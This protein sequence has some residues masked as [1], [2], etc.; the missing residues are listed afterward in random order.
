[1]QSPQ[2]PSPDVPNIEPVVS[3]TVDEIMDMW[4]A[5]VDSV[6]HIK[7]LIDVMQFN[8]RFTSEKDG[9]KCAGNFACSNMP[10]FKTILSAARKRRKRLMW[11]KRVRDRIFDCK[12]ALYKIKQVLLYTLS[13]PEAPELFSGFV[14]VA[15]LRGENI[16]ISFAYNI[17]PDDALHSP[18]DSSENSVAVAA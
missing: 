10:R 5:R 11:M 4:S 16:K 1:M 13:C 3:D 18:D 8:F 6:K 14:F 15:D 7:K 2:S 17:L 9:V 12:T